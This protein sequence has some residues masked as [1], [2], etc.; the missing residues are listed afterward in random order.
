M[1]RRRH[2]DKHLPQRVYLRRGSYFFVDLLGKWHNLGRDLSSMYRTVATLIEVSRSCLTMNNVFDRYLID[3]LPGL[4]AR[5][6][7]DYRGYIQNLRLVFG[8]A[9]PREVTPGHVSDYQA[10][11]AERSVVQ[12]NREKSCLSAVF[13]AALKWHAVDTNPCRL[14]P[15]LREAERDRY[16][17]D[18]E[19]MAVYRLASPTLQC[20]MDLATLTG[21]READLLRLSRSQL[22][23]D[24]IAFTVSK[25]KRRHPRH[26]KTVETAKKLVIEWSPELRAVV[27][28]LKK[29]GPQLR[30]TLLCNLQGKPFTSD[31]FRSNW[32]RLMTKAVTPSE[33]GEPAALAEGF[34]FHDLRAK[35][36][37]DDELEVATERLAHDDPRTTQK[38]Y[39]RKPRRARAGLKILDTSG[40]IGQ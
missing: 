16:V 21:Q 17:T 36:A 33:N 11:R 39:R 31:G 37:S 3:V 34:T 18:A 23:D 24:G 13:T 38:V 9:P 4:A 40:D 35:S 32:H 7:S 27:E 15:K 1:G 8:S 10:K 20:A 26:G 30:P 29:L 25:S 6:Q 28:R 22:F 5:T 14:V 2:G 12:A 19:F